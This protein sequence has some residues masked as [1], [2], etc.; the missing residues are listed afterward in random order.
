[1]SQATALGEA[2]GKKVE[3]GVNRPTLDA[4]TDLAQG[5]LPIVEER[6]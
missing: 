2:R 5:R 1:M 6:R 3:T 4:S